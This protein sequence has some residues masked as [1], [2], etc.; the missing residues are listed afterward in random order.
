MDLPFKSLGIDLQ[1][2]RLTKRQLKKW[3]RS[4]TPHIVPLFSN[5]GIFTSEGD[6]AYEST[7]YKFDSVEE[8]W[9]FA[10]AYK[11]ILIWER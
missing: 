8:F 1:G 4:N 10:R 9:K 6:G 3:E 7:E 5:G 2:H 11:N